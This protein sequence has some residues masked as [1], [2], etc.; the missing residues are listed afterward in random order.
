MKFVDR[1]L[2]WLSFNERILQEAEDKNVSLVDRMKFLA[3]YSSN[4]EEF[5]RVR[6][7]KHHF[8]Q[9]FKGDK[10]NK[11]GYKPSYVLTEISE[12]V[13]RQQERFGSIFNNQLLPEYKENGIELLDATNLSAEETQLAKAY[14]DE[15]LSGR[16][17]LENVAESDSIELINQMVYL[18]FVDENDQWLLKLDYKQFGRFITIDEKNGVK[19]IIQLDDIYKINC[20]KIVGKSC[21]VYAIKASRDA[22]LYIED[23][24]DQDIVKKIKKAI[25]KR[26]SGMLSRLLFDKRIRFKDIDSLRLKLKIGMAG[27]IPGGKYHNFYDFFG[28]PKPAKLDG[29]GQDKPMKIPSRE[30]EGSNDWFATIKQKDILLSFPYQRYDYLT[31]FISRSCEDDNV[32]EISITLYRVAKESAICKALEKA[33]LAGKKVTVLDEVQARFDEESNI[34]WGERLEKAG[35][36][37]IYGVEGLKV[38]AKICLVKR[39]EEGAEQHYCCLSTGNFNE[40]TAE[41]YADHALITTDP[42]ILKDLQEVFAFLK[43]EQDQIDAKLLLV[44]PFSLRSS[45]LQKIKEEIEWVKKGQQGHIK[46]KLNS[47]EDPEMIKAIRQAAD[48]GVYVELIIRGICCYTPL[49]KKQKHHVKVVSVIDGFLEHARIYYFHNGGQEELY[50]ASA[51]WMT[52]NLSQRVEVAFPVRNDVYKQFLID[53]MQIQVNDNLKGRLVIKK[54]NY[55]HGDADETSQQLMLSLV[56]KLEE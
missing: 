54:N 35:A 2:S 13:S 4:L 49:N 18:Y 47:L 17:E 21:E 37:V 11:F 34:Y 55:V 26:E 12:T 41:I 23:E 24:E 7:A 25:Q 5:Y 50:L 39:I 6:V 10:K 8:L 53:E 1:D 15:H 33:A 38:H 9:K 45:L 19:K 36:N 42:E 22:E 46:L 27:L 48:K 31:D 52:R 28:F 44:A 29:E 56:Q 14:Y 51:D 20:D 43:S 40:K 32:S 30:L 3:I 16:Y